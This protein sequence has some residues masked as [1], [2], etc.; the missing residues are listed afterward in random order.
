MQELVC[1]ANI[2]C[3]TGLGL[4]RH[5]WNLGGL[6]IGT[7]VVIHCSTNRIQHAYIFTHVF[8]DSSVGIYSEITHY[9]TQRPVCRTRGTWPGIRGP[10]GKLAICRSQHDAYMHVQPL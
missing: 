10:L 1:S 7:Y 9:P 2:H 8:R 3:S 4:S 6:R 5:F